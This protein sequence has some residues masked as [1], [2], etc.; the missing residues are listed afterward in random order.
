MISVY[1]FDN[2]FLFIGRLRTKTRILGVFCSNIFFLN[3]MLYI[4][5]IG[6]VKKIIGA[7]KEHKLGEE[8]GKQSDQKVF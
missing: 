3:L 4:E 1:P 7:F 2:Y 5:I 6:L 8:L